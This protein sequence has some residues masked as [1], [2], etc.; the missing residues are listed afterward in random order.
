M[1]NSLLPLGLLVLTIGASLWLI[2]GGAARGAGGPAVFPGILELPSKTKLMTPSAELEA[3]NTLTGEAPAGA[4]AW[5]VLLLSGTENE[6]LTNTVLLALGE[7]LTKRGFVVIMDP[8]SHLVTSEPLPLGADGNLR[9]HTVASVL[10]QGG[11]GALTFTTTVQAI[12]VRVPADH[13]VARWFPD[14]PPAVPTTLSITHQSTPRQA[15]PWPEW[16]AALGRSVSSQILKALTL[17]ATV[18][19]TAEVIH[20]TAWVEPG[21]T[22]STSIF[23]RIPSPPQD[24]VVEHLVAFQQPFVRGWI[25]HLTPVPVTTHEGGQ[26]SARAEL[27]RRLERGGWTPGPTEG[28]RLTYSKED[29]AS[30]GT[31]IHRS[32]TITGEEIVEWQERPKPMR[33]WDA[34]TDAAKAGDAA[35][36]TQLYRHRHTAGIPQEQRLLV[37]AAGKP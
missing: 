36:A 17:P 6:P 30:D 3:T 5:R 2:R 12:P 26:R 7:D 24:D 33:L 28:E 27:I 34:W 15:T 35:A 29:H 1:R 13:P 31:T 19:D 4:A 16:Y 23:G 25:G 10:P 9:I 21:Q 14:L 11:P 22:E 8:A 37:P 32:L 20:A 18:T